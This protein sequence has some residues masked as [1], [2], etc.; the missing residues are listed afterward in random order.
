LSEDFQEGRE[1]GGITV[2]NPF[3]SKPE[4]FGLR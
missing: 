3:E 1:F 2:V 4:A